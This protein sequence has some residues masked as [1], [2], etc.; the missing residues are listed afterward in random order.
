MII[1][2]GLTDLT[3]EGTQ[4]DDFLLIEQDVKTTASG[5]RRANNSGRRF[6]VVEGIRMTASEVDS[7]MTLLTNGATA[8]YYT[9]TT[10]PGYCDALD[11]PMQVHIG[12]PKKTRHAGGGEKKYHVEI[13]IEGTEYL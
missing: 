11:F 5:E 7:L 10:V 4:V 1:S 13:E 3:Y 6:K 8:Y 9:P 2:D 12:V